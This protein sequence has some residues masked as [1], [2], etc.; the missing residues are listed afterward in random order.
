MI[1]KKE[2]KGKTSM[3]VICIVED[4]HG[5]IGIAANEKAAKQFLL[6]SEWVKAGTEIWCRDE[7]ERYGGHYVSLIDLYGENWEE[8]FFAMSE[9]Q[10]EDM[11]FFLETWEVCD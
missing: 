11:G 1:V 10:L 5:L 7:N 8:K 9:G 3:T 6:D 2:R 4:N